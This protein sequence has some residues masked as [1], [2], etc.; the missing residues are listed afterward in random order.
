MIHH[1]TAVFLASSGRFLD[2]VQLIKLNN[3]HFLP[4]PEWCADSFLLLHS[5]CWHVCHETLRIHGFTRIPSESFLSPIMSVLFV[6]E[7]LY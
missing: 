2:E 3:L 1:L 5:E 6:S 7:F 4:L